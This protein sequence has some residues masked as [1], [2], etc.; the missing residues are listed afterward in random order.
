VSGWPKK[1][2]AGFKGRQVGTGGWFPRSAITS[3]KWPF[4]LNFTVVASGVA[5]V[6]FS[7]EIENEIERQSG[8]H[9]GSKSRT[10]VPSMFGK[11]R[12]FFVVLLLP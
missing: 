1:A 4:Q 11:G 7:F 5:S 6:G 9:H 3:K 12:G 10:L 2:C 8:W